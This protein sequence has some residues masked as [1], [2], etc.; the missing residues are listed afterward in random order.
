MVDVIVKKLG[1]KCVVGVTKEETNNVEFSAASLSLLR[2]FV[3]AVGTTI[4]HTA[5]T[6]DSATRQ[7]HVVL[8][9]TD[10]DA[11]LAVHSLLCCVAKEDHDGADDAAVPPILVAKEGGEGKAVEVDEEEGGEADAAPSAVLDLLSTRPSKRARR[12]QPDR[13][14][15]TSSALSLLSSS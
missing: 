12:S 1:E 10:V 14:N 2:R 3:D 11:A 9:D 6:A 8:G 7:A 15:G 13:A 5:V 4:L